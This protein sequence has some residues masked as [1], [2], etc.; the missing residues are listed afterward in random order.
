MKMHCK[1]AMGS[2]AQKE[3]SICKEA[4]AAG[5]FYKVVLLGL[6]AEYEVMLEGAT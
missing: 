1:I 4:G 5:K 2:T 6:P 3:G